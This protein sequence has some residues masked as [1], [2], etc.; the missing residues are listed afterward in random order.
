[1]AWANWLS[2]GAYER[3]SD[4]WFRIG[5]AKPGKRYIWD[6]ATECGV[7]LLRCDVGISS[8]KLMVWIHRQDGKTPLPLNLLIYLENAASR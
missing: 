7:H 2:P 5:L 8:Y 4:S 6:P 3:C 1:M